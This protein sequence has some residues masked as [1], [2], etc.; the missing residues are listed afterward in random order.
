M[1]TINHEI[2]ALPALLEL[3]DITGAIITIDAMGTQTEIVRL[4]RQKKADYV[5]TLKSNHPTL[6]NKRQNLVCDGESSTV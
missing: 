2:T 4:I 6:Y 1:K 3:I 5:V